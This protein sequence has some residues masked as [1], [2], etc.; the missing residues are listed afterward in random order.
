M[1]RYAAHRGSET[2]IASTE[3]PAHRGG[4]RSWLLAL[5]LI[6][7]AGGQPAHSGKYPALTQ[8]SPR[9]SITHDR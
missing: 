8:G 3:L 7:A 6:A 4:A 2:R 9:H 5:A 1:A